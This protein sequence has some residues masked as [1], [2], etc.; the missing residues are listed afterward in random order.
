MIVYKA[1][2]ILS[3]GQLQ[4]FRRGNQFRYFGV[5]PSLPGMS[6]KFLNEVS[7]VKSKCL[8]ILENTSRTILLLDEDLKGLDIHRNQG[9]NTEFMKRLASNIIDGSNATWMTGSNAIH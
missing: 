8:F 9:E 4:P 5:A 6:S 7:F 3:S 2:R 1:E